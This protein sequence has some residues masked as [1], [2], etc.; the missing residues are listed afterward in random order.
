MSVVQLRRLH[1]HIQPLVLRS[2][3]DP[4]PSWQ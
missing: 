2:S 4:L 3:S 1:Q